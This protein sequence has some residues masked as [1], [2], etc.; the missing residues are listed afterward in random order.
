VAGVGRARPGLR[1]SPHDQLNLGEFSR[2][3]AAWAGQASP[4][5]LPPP[6]P[7]LGL[8]SGEILWIPGGVCSVAGVGQAR[9]GLRLPPPR[10]IGSGG[11]RR[12]GFSFG[13]F[14]RDGGARWAPCSA[15]GVFFAVGRVGLFFGRY[16]YVAPGSRRDPNWAG[17]KYDQ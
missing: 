5:S 7:R 3:L 17:L 12:L 13:E 14:V 2:S 4:P 16:S 15:A 8:E 1:L 9:P 10:P 11:L 6:L